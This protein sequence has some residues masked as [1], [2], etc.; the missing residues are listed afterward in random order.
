MSGSAETNQA[1]IWFQVPS[2][3][4][5]QAHLCRGHLLPGADRAPGGDGFRRGEHQGA[6]EVCAG[7]HGEGEAGFPTRGTP[8]NGAN[9]SVL[10]TPNIFN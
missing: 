1:S 7:A 8:R 6:V 3:G 5:H 9:R 4:V 10:G 2:S